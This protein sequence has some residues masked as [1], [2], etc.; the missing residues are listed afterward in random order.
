MPIRAILNFSIQQARTVSRTV[1]MT[2]PTGSPTSIANRRAQFA[3]A[4]GFDWDIAPI[5]KSVEL[6]SIA[7]T[8]GEYDIA[9][10]YCND[11]LDLAYHTGL[12]YR[13]NHTG[14]KNRKLRSLAQQLREV[15]Y[16]S[17][18]MLLDLQIEYT[19]KRGRDLDLAT[20]DETLAEIH[21]LQTMRQ[22]RM[23][24]EQAEWQRLGITSED[25]IKSKKGFFRSIFD[26]LTGRF[27][28]AD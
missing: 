21:R 3:I 8:D 28:R 26:M 2:S 24:A 5:Q 12:T 27:N 13:S 22:N 14:F 17:E 4:E 18:M 6:A 9:V 20:A 23:G 11:G 7:F 16:K 1:P 15:R 25:Q 10:E 19:W